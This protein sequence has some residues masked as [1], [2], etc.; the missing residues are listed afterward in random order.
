MDYDLITT[1]D[2]LEK[3]VS[4]LAG[5]DLLAI[6]IKTTGPDPHSDTIRLI[7]IAAES[8]PAILIDFLELGV[9]S[10]EPLKLLLASNAEKVLHNA[11]STLKFLKTM[12]IG[13]S[14]SI[15]DTMLAG[16]ILSCGDA[17]E[18]SLGHLSQQYLKE[19]LP[20]DKLDFCGNDLGSQHFFTA[21]RDTRIILKLKLALAG[22]LQKLGLVDV[23]ELELGCKP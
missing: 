7:Q 17:S 15:F 10:I 8:G 1:T 21:A 18:P 14:A 9:A 3:A 4:A 2:F 11:K 22:H 19:F 13:V 12:G 23:A 16:Q 20:N 5:H 6:D